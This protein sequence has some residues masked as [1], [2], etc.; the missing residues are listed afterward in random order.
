MI[1]AATVSGPSNSI[2]VAIVSARSDAL[3]PCGSR[4]VFVLGT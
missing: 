3:R 2:L 1:T 4:N